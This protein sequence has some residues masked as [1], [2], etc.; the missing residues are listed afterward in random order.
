MNNSDYPG[1]KEMALPLA[2]CIIEMGGKIRFSR[3]GE[4]LEKKL[5]EYYNLSSEQLLRTDPGSNSK[6]NRVWRNHI[7]YARLKAVHRKI[8]GRPNRDVWSV[9]SIVSGMGQSAT[10]LSRLITTSLFPNSEDQI[11]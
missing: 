3:D 5:G 4:R 9:T 2:R 8:I 7:Q 6:G 11:P 10:D 1:Q